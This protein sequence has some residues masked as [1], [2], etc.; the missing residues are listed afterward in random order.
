VRG[1]LEARGKDVWRAK[2]YLGRDEDGS[3]QYLTRTIHAS[4]RKA[5]DVLSQMLVEAGLGAHVVTDGTLR[6]LASR[7]W[8]MAEPNLSP[9]TTREYRRLLWKV[10]V[11]RLGDKKVRAL[12]AADIDAMYG[13]LSRKLSAQ[14]VHHVHAVLRRVLNQGVKWGWLPTNPALRASPP[15]AKRKPI[16]PPR[17]EQVTRL[18]TEA[19][20]RDP[21]LGCFLRLA[22]VTGARRGE[23][24][25]LRWSDV[26]F[27][28]P[29]I[30]LSRAIVGGRND[31]LLEKDTKTHA[32]RRISLDVVTAD[33]LKA[34]RER[35][36]ERAE[37]VEGEL[38]D[39]AFIFS[40][41]VLGSRPWRPDRVTLAFARLRGDFGLDGVR[42]HDL[43]HF[44][45][46]R[47]LAAGVPVRTVSGRL[48][49]ASPATTLNVYAAWLQESD[50]MA[51]TVLSD[52]LTN[53]EKAPT[54]SP[55]PRARR[56]ARGAGAR[57]RS[58]AVRAPQ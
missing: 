39:D 19:D 29:S 30:T 2:I 47:L 23:L 8:T 4:K 32:G 33:V 27:D 50:Q 41:D 3:K 49:H 5:E 10:I 34:R 25:A 37:A 46:T 6:E 35:A 18:L 43:R 12:R 15:K 16:N 40:D 58:A 13:E 28:G 53:G 31:A 48:G 44:A 22:A 21:D 57:P 11:P 54:S 45:A 56:A 9:T 1:H 55:S 51:A 38:A 36:E 20:R 14:S 42:L 52:L 24:C 17:P 7:W 26:D